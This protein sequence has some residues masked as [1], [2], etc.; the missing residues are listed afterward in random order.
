LAGASAP[1]P[2]QQ[3]L[4]AMSLDLDAV[5]QNGRP[6]AITQEQITRSVDRQT[7]VSNG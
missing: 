6:D 4:N 2:D 7:A 5:R 3:R 1:S